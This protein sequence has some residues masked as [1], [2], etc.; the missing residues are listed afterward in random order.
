MSKTSVRK[1]K[2][3]SK[4][5]ETGINTVLTIM[6]PISIPFHNWYC[7]KIFFTLDFIQLVARRQYKPLATI[8]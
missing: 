1:L 2:F 5:S 8:L 4:K 7:S 3:G 6:P